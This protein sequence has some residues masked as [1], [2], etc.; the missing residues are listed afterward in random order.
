M[1]RSIGSNPRRQLIPAKR[2]A[3][4]DRTTVDKNKPRFVLC[5]RFR[6]N[7]RLLARSSKC[8]KAMSYASKTA[9]TP[10]PS[11]TWAERSRSSKAASRKQSAFLISGPGE[12]IWIHYLREGKSQHII[13][14]E[15]MPESIRE[16]M[17]TK[18]EHIELIGQSGESA[19][20]LCTIL[21]KQNYG[22][23]AR[24]VLRGVNSHR[25]RLGKKVQSSDAHSLNSIIQGSLRG[26]QR[27]HR[28]PHQTI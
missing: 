8:K 4:S 25:T 1:E 15:H 10:F 18:E 13:L 6:T 11:V 7:C 19:R 14:R 3:I 16:V 21:L 9:D 20:K 5:R 23:V 26:N 2:L 27:R 24:K 17:Q 28:Q 12:R 22:E